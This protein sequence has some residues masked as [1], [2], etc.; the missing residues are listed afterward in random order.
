MGLEFT[1]IR[2]LPRSQG[3]KKPEL[4]GQDKGKNLKG[5]CTGDQRT[6]HAAGFDV[7]VTAHTVV[8]N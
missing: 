8:I 6:L 3:E 5:N 1:L 4:S 2:I 7:S